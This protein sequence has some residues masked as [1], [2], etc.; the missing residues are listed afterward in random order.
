M[1]EKVDWSYSLY[2]SD[3]TSLSRRKDELEDDSAPR[4][5]ANGGVQRCGGF[6]DSFVFV[7]LHSSKN[8]G[9]LSMW[10]Q[11]RYDDSKVS[12]L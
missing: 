1:F 7:R 10:T 3:L 12:S 4:F 2:R 11:D 8:C 6:P 9:T 5:W